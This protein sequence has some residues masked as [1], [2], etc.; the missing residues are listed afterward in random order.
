MVRPRNAPRTASLRILLRGGGTPFGYPGGDLS[1]GS[2]PQLA[3]DPGHVIVG[4]A[5]GD[6][7]L[8]GDL[9]VGEPPRDEERDFSLAAGEPLHSFAGRWLLFGHGD[10]RRRLPLLF[11]REG[12]LYGLPQRHRLAPGPRRCEPL[13]SQLRASPAQVALVVG[14]REDNGGEVCAVSLLHAFHG[15]PQP[16]GSERLLPASGHA[17]QRVEAVLDAL[18]VIQLR[19]QAQAF[20][21]Q[22]RGTLIVAPDQRQ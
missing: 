8:R 6:G 10:E 15:P 18:F 4:R 9:A 22:R 1:S 3:Q 7:K 19:R 14:K 13:L 20:P 11:N 12:V 17:R 21:Q 5:R 2:E 16:G